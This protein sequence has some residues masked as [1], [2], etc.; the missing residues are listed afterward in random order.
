MQREH[1]D[2]PEALLVA[3][4]E[5]EGA[6]TLA[7]V[8]AA[9]GGD[10]AHAES[11]RRLL[12]VRLVHPGHY[13]AL[14]DA[15]DLVTEREQAWQRH[16]EDVCATAAALAA[17]HEARELKLAESR[18]PAYAAAAEEEIARLDVEDER[19]RRH[20]ERLPG[21]GRLLETALAAAQQALTAAQQV[22]TAAAVEA[23]VQEE[24]AWCEELVALL[25]P[26][27]RLLA[28]APWLSQRAE[29]LGLRTGREHGQE[30][31]REVALRTVRSSAV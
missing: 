10:E 16:A 12:A 30:M 19:L 11:W 4:F 23:F 2:L 5:G 20:Q 24:A 8:Q 6:P 9:A 1:A 31:L 18:H 17:V 13:L 26:A 15:R 25:E 14:F 28:E 3:F 21:A 22:L 7:A 27:R 29:Q